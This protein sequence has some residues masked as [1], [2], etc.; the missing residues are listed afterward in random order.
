MYPKERWRHTEDGNLKI[1]K[2]KEQAPI[3]HLTDNKY[4]NFQDSYLFLSLARALWPFFLSH[5]PK[6]G[7]WRYRGNT[8]LQIY[9]NKDQ[10]STS[11]ITVN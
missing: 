6:R 9:K 1:F 8:N 3:P 11:N 2:N 4:N 7:Q 5:G 10:A